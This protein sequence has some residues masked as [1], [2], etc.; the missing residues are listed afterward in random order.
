MPNYR[1]FVVIHNLLESDYADERIEEIEKAVNSAISDAAD[2]RFKASEENMLF[3]FPLDPSVR[4]AEI[5]V[6]VDMQFLGPANINLEE[7]DEMTDLIRAALLLVFRNRG[8][9]VAIVSNRWP[10]ASFSPRS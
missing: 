1:G 2:G 7:R 6:V 3:V 10:T 5:P 8:D 9:V 4:S